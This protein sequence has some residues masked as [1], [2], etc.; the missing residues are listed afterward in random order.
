MFL[1]AHSFFHSEARDAAEK[2]LRDILQI[3]GA[4]RKQE[5]DNLIA[6]LERDVVASIKGSEAVV[7]NKCL[8]DLRSLA[9]RA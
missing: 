3:E 1:I 2:Q 6:A 9:Q 8:S 5:Q 4:L 7:L